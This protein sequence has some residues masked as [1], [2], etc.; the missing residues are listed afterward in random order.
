MMF[1]KNYSSILL[2][3]FGIILLYF[4][5]ATLFNILIPFFNLF[6][7][8]YSLDVFCNMS[9]TNSGVQTSTTTQIIHTN[10]TW[11]DTIRTIFIY[12]IGSLRYVASR[13]AAARAFVI[14]SAV[15]GD[16]TSRVLTN[17]VNDPNSLQK[18]ATNWG[19]II[20]P[21]ST[22]NSQANVTLDQQSVT[23]IETKVKEI[24]KDSSSRAECV[25][26]STA[27]FSS[28]DINSMGEEWLKCIMSYLQ[29]ILEPIPV[30]YSNELLASQ[31]QFIAVLSFLMIIITIFLFIVFTFNA[32]ILIYRDQII[33]YFKNKYIRA[34]LNLQTK[35]IALELIFL[36]GWIL[37]SLYII[38]VGLQFIA[39]HPIT[40]S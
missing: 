39:R 15:T 11:A 22:D 35:L 10:N 33:G 12:G 9:D 6:S 31:I 3:L 5:L 17:V 24:S 28:T 4:I 25:G 21:G 7:D 32:I 1:F 38:S 13:S 16:L 40:F 14:T 19:A 23:V 18:L 29:P 37:Y 8:I 36:S 20:S 27:N 30:N 34:Y 26:D 2:R